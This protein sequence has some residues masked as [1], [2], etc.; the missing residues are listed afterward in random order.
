MA[1]RGVIYSIILK[2]CHVKMNALLHFFP[3]SVQFGVFCSEKTGSWKTS[4]A[5]KGADIHS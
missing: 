2:P 1:G 4:A 3:S 5:A